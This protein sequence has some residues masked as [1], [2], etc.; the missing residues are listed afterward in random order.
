MANGTPKEYSPFTPGQPVPV[1]FFVGRI[2]E[3]T[4]LRDAVREAATGRLRT[5]FL[6]GERGIGKSSLASFVKFLAEREEGALCAHVLLGGVTGLEEVV[7]TIFDRLL[8]DSL[9]KA[10]QQRIRDFLGTHVREVGLF[11]VTVEFSASPDD[12]RR[13]VRDFVSAISELSKRVRDERRVIFLILDDISGLASSPAFADWLKSKVDEIATSGLGVPLCLVLVGL[14]ER[15][16]SLIEGQPSLDR[17][18]ELVEIR[19]WT[20]E[21]TSE[22]FK[23]TFE[24][25]GVTIDDA[26][27]DLISDVAGGLPVLAHEIGDATFRLD[28]DNHI[29]TVDAFKGLVTAA[30]IVGRKYLEPAVL[31]AIRSPRYRAILGKLTGQL[32]VSFTRRELAEK[33]DPQESRIL[34]NF[35]RRMRQLGVLRP[36]HERGPGAYRFDNLLH[37]LYISLAA[38]EQKRAP[39][40][41]PS[42]K[43]RP[44]ATSG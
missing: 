15:R 26:A 18:F 19:P 3:V 27:L 44:P 34:D 6:S 5:V 22:F 10:W 8:K 17:V 24:K 33:L 23:G 25:A 39:R 37:R 43:P 9:G 16:R 28:S 38:A 20:T 12:L 1:D 7:R 14:E 40:E 4:R 30:E 11:G 31:H 32:P 42:A 2:G 29:D 35:L 21:E 13:A 41:S 36:E